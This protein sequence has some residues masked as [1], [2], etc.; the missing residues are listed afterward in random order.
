MGFIIECT[1]C[2]FLEIVCC[3]WIKAINLYIA[4]VIKF[5]IV[6]KMPSI[7][8]FPCL[9][10]AFQSQPALVDPSATVLPRHTSFLM[11]SHIWLVYNSDFIAGKPFMVWGFWQCVCGRGDWELPHYGKSW[12]F[13]HWRYHWYSSWVPWVWEMDSNTTHW[14]CRWICYRTSELSYQD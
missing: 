9:C 8:S 6:C 3:I 2:N 13:S 5:V 11:Q 14:I 1:I 10:L 4:F 7:P 12:M